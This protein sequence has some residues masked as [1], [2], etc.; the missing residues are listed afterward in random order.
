MP[1]VLA[2]RAAAVEVVVSGFSEVSCGEGKM[3]QSHERRMESIRCR[4]W[5]RCDLRVSYM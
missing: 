1:R 2:L 5:G 3:N 4:K